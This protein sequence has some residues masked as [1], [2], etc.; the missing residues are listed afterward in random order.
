MWS[1]SVERDVNRPEATAQKVCDDIYTCL[2]VCGL[3]RNYKYPGQSR[4]T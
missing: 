3:V 1:E 2:L 4:L